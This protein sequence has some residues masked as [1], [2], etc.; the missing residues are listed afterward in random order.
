M[1][2]AVR[3][4]V[5]VA[6]SACGRLRFEPHS[7]DDARRGDADEV[8]LVHEDAGVDTLCSAPIAADALSVA[9]SHVCARNGMAIYCWG[10]NVSGQ[11]GVGDN[12]MRTTPA[13]I[14]GTFTNLAPAR[15]DHTCAISR[16]RLPP[17]WPPSPSLL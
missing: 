13:Q 8:M 5:L 16:R 7:D 6:L 10:N 9:R 14:T 3:R 11:L 17:A 12:V 2:D 15:G 4:L 1:L